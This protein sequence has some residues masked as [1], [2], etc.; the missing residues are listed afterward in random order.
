MPLALT[1]ATQTALDAGSVVDR[2][3]LLF[4]LGSGLY[5]FWTGIGPFTNPNDGITYIGAG[6]L[7][8][9]DGIKQSSD[10]SAVQ[11]VVRLTAIENT[12]LTPDT[13]ATIETEVYHQRPCTISTAYFDPD[14][15]SLLSVETEYRGYIDQIVHSETIDGAA[16]L[17][18]HLE[19]RFRDH[20]RSGYRVRSDVDQRRISA[21]DN[22]LR[23]VTAVATEKIEFGRT[24]AQVAASQAVPVTK[25]K[26]SFLERIF[27]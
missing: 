21:S 12:D 27:G 14:S 22:G 3:L 10:L 20:Q 11:V 2:G 24:E 19:S 26:K 6:S 13:L 15:Y 8:E 16:V 5:G 9:V 1:P 23:H 18:A 7:I 25:P 17:E 4:D